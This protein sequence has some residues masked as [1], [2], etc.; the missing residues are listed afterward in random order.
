MAAGHSWTEIQDYS[1]GQ[2][3]S[4]LEAA[5][6]IENRRRA[7]TICDLRL[8]AWGEVKVVSKTVEKLNGD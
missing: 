6:M 7:Q 1:F 2:I 8:A 5:V 4:F 3:K